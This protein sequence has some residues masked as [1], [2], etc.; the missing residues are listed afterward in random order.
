M[1]PKSHCEENEPVTSKDCR[2]QHRSLNRTLWGFSALLV[3][4]MVAIGWSWDAADSAEES[5]DKAEAAATEVRRQF[6]IHDAKQGAV[7]GHI[8]DTLERIEETGKET[9]K[10]VDKIHRNGHKS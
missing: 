5:A 3:L 7:M 1:S 10:L 2:T 9:R 6:D 4:L 8:N